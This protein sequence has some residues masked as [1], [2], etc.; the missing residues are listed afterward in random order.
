EPD[1]IFDTARAI[2]RLKIREADGD[3]Y[4]AKARE[5]LFPQFSQ[6]A[7]R[8]A[9]EPVRDDRRAASILLEGFLFT[10]RLSC[11]LVRN[12]RVIDAARLFKQ[13]L[14]PLTKPIDKIGLGNFP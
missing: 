10:Q 14:A 9:I 13:A 3:G 2:L 6:D 7:L 4:S 11:P 1:P 5:F 12:R 8:H